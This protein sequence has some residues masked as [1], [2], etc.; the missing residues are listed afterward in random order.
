MDN[1]RAIVLLIVL[2]SSLQTSGP[3]TQMSDEVAALHRAVFEIQRGEVFVDP[4]LYR[5]LALRY[6]YGRGVE[7]DIPQGCALLWEAHAAAH[8]P[9]HDQTGIDLAQALIDRV[10]ER[11]GGNFLATRHTAARFPNSRSPR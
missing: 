5:D 6:L 1:S 4:A 9:G 2:S 10:T 11:S 7:H 3:G 8:A